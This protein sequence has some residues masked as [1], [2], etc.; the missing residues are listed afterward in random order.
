MERMGEEEP[1]CFTCTSTIYSI[2]LRMNSRHLAAIWT[3]I[4]LYYWFFFLANSVLALNSSFFRRNCL[5]FAPQDTPN[6]YWSHDARSREI[7]LCITLHSYLSQQSIIHHH[8]HHHH[9]YGPLFCFTL[10]G[11]G[12]LED[13]PRQPNRHRWQGKL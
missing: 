12:N 1:V 4:D 13:Q 2:I 7:I 10:S 9:H 11:R 6:S 5:L 8:H 3:N